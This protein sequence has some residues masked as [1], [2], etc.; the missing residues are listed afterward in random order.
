MKILVNGI[1]QTVLSS[2][3]ECSSSDICFEAYSPELLSSAQAVLSSK[4]G[5]S[6]GRD[7][8]L[9]VLWVGEDPPQ[10][11]RPFLVLP[12]S[13]QTGQIVEG[14]MALE[15]VDP[16][17]SNKF[18]ILVVDDNELVLDSVCAILE[19]DFDV[20]GTTSALEGLSY[21]DD[22][23]YDVLMTDLMMEEM[24]GNALVRQALSRNENLKIIVMTGYSS[25]EAAI[26]AL[27]AGAYD[28]LE[29]PLLPADVLQSLEKA[30]MSVRKDRKRE[31][32][33]R[34]LRQ[35]SISNTLG[36]ENS[37]D[38]LSILSES[39]LIES[40]LQKSSS[41]DQQISGLNSSAV[42]PGTPPF[43][44]AFEQAG[45]KS[46]RFLTRNSLPKNSI[47]QFLAALSSEEI[48]YGEVSIKQDSIKKE[49]RIDWV[50][51]TP[52][53]DQRVFLEILNR[54]I[55]GE[56]H[57]ELGISLANLRR[58]FESCSLLL[59]ATCPDSRKVQIEF[60]F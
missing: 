24:H 51:D 39:K 14:L 41:L 3:H 10:E 12:E 28:Y 45:I 6:L 33:L 53:E 2:F 46:D 37:E 47:E 21:L 29:K 52:F 60:Y 31:L 58:C 32:E 54:K 42:F 35:E 34:K 7:L 44:T 48:S 8:S 40:L 11:P 27:K 26:E 9:P 13:P 59:N 19:E 25:K 4:E 55:S 36:F 17:D 18:R 49:W 38:E 20:V 43:S 5:E 23:D 57:G 22:Q 15:E 50:I 30:F 56:S 1:S 16:R